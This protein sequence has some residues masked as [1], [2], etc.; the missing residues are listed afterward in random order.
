MSGLGRCVN[1]FGAR[2]LEGT[3]SGLPV[4]RSDPTLSL[5]TDFE[6]YTVFRPGPNQAD[7]LGVVLD[8]TVA[9]STALAPLRA[10]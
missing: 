3:L 8:Q 10:S 2:R 6:N 5:Q 9:W 7:A 4:E 1:T